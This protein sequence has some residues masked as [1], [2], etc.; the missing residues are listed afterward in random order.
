MLALNSASP[1]SRKRLFFTVFTRL[2]CSKGSWINLPVEHRTVGWI[3][4]D[5]GA[6]NRIGSGQ[7]HPVGAQAV[8][9]NLQMP[10]EMIARPGKSE[11][12]AGHSGGDVCRG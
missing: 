6:G 10:A 12:I 7:R 3:D 2:H 5:V 11:C 4:C 8:C 9:L 1:Q